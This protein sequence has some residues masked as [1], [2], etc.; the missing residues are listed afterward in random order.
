MDLHTVGSWRT[1]RTRAELGLAPGEALLAGGSWLF[2]E[3]QQ[4]VTG[5]VDLTGMGWPSWTI[6]EGGLS[7]SA[8]CTIAQL[9]EPPAP[10]DWAAAPLF[11]QCAE[12]FL[13]S[14]KIWNTAT[15]GGNLC[16]A[17]PA[18]AMISLAT[19]LDADVV[20][21]TP[22]G[23]QRREQV[24][25]FVRG[26]RSTSLQP[27]EILRSI[28]FDL[29]ALRGRTA[30]RKFALTPLGRSS[31]VVTGRLDADGRITLA[32]TAATPRPQVFHFGQAPTDDAVQRALATVGQWYDDA[33]GT[34]D[35]RA[36]ISLGLAYEV[37]EEL[38]SS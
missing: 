34:A 17:L 9:L 37:C 27:G 1:P 18:G 7:V 11:R 36:A 12:A 20:V 31:S 25:S 19:A 33:H 15:V 8:T 30:F 10:A 6:H 38:R 13:M 28:E 29:A 23:G 2:S 32:V 22:D 24:A 3:P 21:W 5:L 16:L 35:W 14:F 4:A 26:V